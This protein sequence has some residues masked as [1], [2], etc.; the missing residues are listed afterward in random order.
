MLL[1]LTPQIWYVFSYFNNDALPLFL[2]LLLA[3]LA[4][5][6]RA[7]LVAVL[8][9]PLRARRRCFRSLG[10]GVLLGLL[11]LTKSN[12]L[13]FLGFVVF[14]AIWKALGFAAAALARGERRDLPRPHAELRHDVGGV[15][16]RVLA[17]GAAAVADVGGAA[18]WRSRATRIGS[19]TRRA[20][21]S[22]GRS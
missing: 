5:G 2:S 7:A 4:F 20:R 3:D 6:A 13:P 1:L 9:E 19:A 10:S 18:A 14:F 22:R 17:I 21:R 16:A 11:V 8:S 15:A 12:Y